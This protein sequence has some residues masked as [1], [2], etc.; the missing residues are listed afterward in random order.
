MWN[1][2][3][4]RRALKH[5]NETLAAQ[6]QAAIPTVY[7]RL[8]MGQG[9]YGSMLGLGGPDEGSD[10]E[11]VR[12]FR[13]WNYVAISRICYKIAEA[14]PN[15]SRI[16]TDDE[17]RQRLT[18]SQRQH[19]RQRYGSVMQA[20][21]DLEPVA[22]GH[23]L[24]RLMHTVNPEDWWGTF[25]YETVMF[26]QL[27]GQFYWWV[28][29]NN[30]G[31]PGELW[32][33]P[34]QWVQPKY[35]KEGS[36]LGYEVTPDGDAR[37]KS[38]IP[39]DQII[40]G[41]HKSPMGKDQAHSPT[42]AGSQWIDNSESIEA[43][44]WQ[45]FQNGPLPSVSIELDPE[46]YAKP[47]PDVLRAVKDR[48]VA[49]YGGTAR[50]GEPMIAPPGMKVTPFSMKPSEMDFPDTIDQVRDQVLALHGVPKVIAGITTDVNRSTIYGAN[51]IF[52]ESTVNPLL[53]LLAGIMNEKLAPRF[54]EGL[55]IWFDDARPA[56]A[57]EEREETKLDWQMGAITPNERRS[58]RGREPIED[59]AADSAYI[60]LA[61]QPVGGTA[62]EEE[63]SDDI[64]DDNPA[65][66]ETDDPDEAIEDMEENEAARFHL[67][68]SSNGAKTNG[69]VRRRGDGFDVR[70]NGRG[71]NG[72]AV[73]E[74]KA[75]VLRPTTGE[76]H[77]EGLARPARQRRQ[78]RRGILT[79]RS[80]WQARRMERVFKAWKRLRDAQEENITLAIGMYFEKMA[81]RAGERASDILRADQPF[82][83]DELWEDAD[84]DLWVQYVSPAIITA[85]LTGTKFEMEQLGIEMPEPDD[86]VAASL[87]TQ[88]EPIRRANRDEFFE[89]Y[90]GS[91]DI[92]VEMP[93][94][95][96]EDIIQYLKRR[97]IPDWMEIT[98]T[99]RKKI[100]KRIAT[101][102]EE[103]WSGRDIVREV[104]SIIRRGAYKGQAMTIARTEGTSAMNHSAQTVRDLNAIPKKIWISAMDK[105]TR[106][107]KDPSSQWNHV[108][109]NTQ[110]VPNASTFTVSGEQLMYPG[111]R[112]GSGANI[113]NCR[114]D[115]SGMVDL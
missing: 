2:L 3:K 48:F 40:T 31:L 28:I 102:L 87:V 29:D 47:D 62:L 96:Q 101:A 83:A 56:D 111:D 70:G 78:G 16:I 71:S 4:T 7:D 109:P 18:V 41:K 57:E 107:M 17:E 22:D 52:C 112:N 69:K 65:G 39:A 10:N 11:L 67:R 13:L 68:P 86:L 38:L 32:V 30:A 51:L 66:D 110:T 88:R 79:P 85:M 84:V 44:R 114:C 74:A 82:I 14:F 27:T 73:Q 115:S 19:I 72:Q 45:T 103:G 81:V 60:P 1:W 76:L 9:G 49:R 94:E 21:E 6:L 34:T 105:D 108:K 55:R 58:E 23:P 95:V 106:G 46:H 53:S 61:I 25:I 104:Q 15:V 8:G 5:E 54:G 99:Q 63:I 92:F 24:L 42:A 64:A 91:P 89:R 26:W 37:R 33:L 50:A 100:E 35:D 59:R 97:E 77:A 113:I 93:P 90:P 36:L 98:N 75:K 80:V 43:A 12:H 20:H